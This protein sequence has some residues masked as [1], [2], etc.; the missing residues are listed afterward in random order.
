[1]RPRLVFDRDGMFVKELIGF[2]ENDVPDSVVM[3]RPLIFDQTRNDLFALVDGAVVIREQTPE[4]V[5]A[6]RGRVFRAALQDRLFAVLFKMENRI[7]GLEEKNEI[8]KETYRENLKKILGL[9]TET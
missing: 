7:R 3:E 9:G 6:S 2:A 8:T 4:E 1:M 5:E